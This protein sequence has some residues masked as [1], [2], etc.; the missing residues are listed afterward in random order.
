MHRPSP[1]LLPLLLVLLPLLACDPELHRMAVAAERVPCTGV[2]NQMCLLVTDLDQ[3]AATPTLFYDG[4][5]GYQHQWG[6]AV[7]IDYTLESIDDPP[8]DG[9]SQRRTAERVEVVSTA[10]AGATFTTRFPVSSQPWFELGATG[11]VLIDGTPVVSPDEL[12][13]RVVG[14]LEQALEVVMAY[15]GAGGL[16]LRSATSVP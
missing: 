14:P 13:A 4:I 16:A 9:S 12:R 3:A 15:D 10:A 1:S 8:A 5:A 2:G 6:R 11:V 7:E